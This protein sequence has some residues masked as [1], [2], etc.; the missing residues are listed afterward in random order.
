ELGERGEAVVMSASAGRVAEELLGAV[1]RA[2]AVAVE[3][4]EGVLAVGPR[5]EHLLAGPEEV[6]PHALVERA[7]VD[8]VTVEVED[9]RGAGAAAVR[10]RLGPRWTAPLRREQPPLR[11]RAV[12]GGVHCRARGFPVRRAVAAGPRRRERR[13]YVGRA[14]ESAAVDLLGGREL[15]VDC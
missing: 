14:R 10:A 1:D 9:Q 5:G 6:E 3:R 13:R 15:R 2:V 11:T 12:A 7:Q 8:T 4:E